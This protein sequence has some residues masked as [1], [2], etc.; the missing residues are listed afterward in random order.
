M[1]ISPYL[2]LYFILIIVI[3]GMADNGGIA[4]TLE[5]AGNSPFAF[6]TTIFLDGLFHVLFIVPVV[7]LYAILRT[8]WPVRANLLLVAGAW[9]ML[10]GSTKALITIMSFNQLVSAYVHADAALRAALIPMAASQDGLRMALQ[11]MD[12]LGVLC[13]WV[14]VSVL[15]AATGRARAVR[16][17]GWIM[18][19]A[20]LSPDP[21]FLLVV[22]LSPAWLY[23]LGRWMKRL[24]PA[25]EG[26]FKAQPEAESGL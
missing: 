3:G 15:P 6:D 20:I 13:V 10:M 5:F 19:V 22:L 14:L 21:S 7:A 1:V 25:A 26:I 23:L 24:V 8:N 9:Q 2:I 11:W 4:Q 12:S 16:W 18:A 17:L